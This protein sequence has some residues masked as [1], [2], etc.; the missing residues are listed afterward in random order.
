[1]EALGGAASVISVA[2]LA[3]QIAESFTK[4]TKFCKSIK[5]APADIQRMLQELQILSYIVLSITQLYEKN[6]LP[7]K[8]QTVI[9]LCLSL[10]D[11]EASKLSNLCLVLESRLNSGKRII[12]TWARVQTVLSESKIAALIEHLERAK[13]A[14]QLLQHLHIL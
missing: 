9:T 11:D 10:I 8:N 2:S 14:L 7:E 5:E 13:S 4:V 1:M 3:I 12:R 6:S